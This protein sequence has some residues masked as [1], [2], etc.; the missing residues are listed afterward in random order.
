MIIDIKELEKNAL[1]FWPDG[2]AEMERNSSIIPKLIETQ[3]KF[4]SLLNIADA[5]PYAWKKVLENSKQLSANLFLK[6]LIVL[7][8]ISGEKL[9]RFKTELPKVFEN[10]TMEFSWNGRNYLYEFQTLSGKK[11]WNNKHLKVDGVGLTTAEELNPI[12]EDITNLILFGGSAIADNIPNEIEEKCN[13]GT[14]IGQKKELDAFVRQRYI[15]VSR[16]TG[17]A[18]ANSLGNLAQRFV[19]EFLQ[20]RLPKWDFSKKHIDK[21]SQ[22]KRTLLSYDIVAKSPKGKICAIEVSFQVTTNST[23][24]RKAG[25]AQARQIQLKKAGHK[26]AY[27]IDG[28]G[29]F[30]RSSALRTICQFSDCTVTFKDSELKKLSEFLMTLDK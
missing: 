10:D 29:N 7:S 27:I 9:M 3:D 4:I 11:T 15:W 17:G 23:I 24:E 8:D 20:E 14:L 19:V 22:N 5:E 26:I 1:K 16:I 30:E 28:A 2:I 21:I 12:I 25:Q 18:A 13:I 6:H